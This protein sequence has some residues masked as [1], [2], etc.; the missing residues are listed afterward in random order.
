M[1]SS[2]WVA[3]DLLN[4]ENLSMWFVNYRN[5]P[6]Q[7]VVAVNLIW[8][9]LLFDLPFTYF[10]NIRV[11]GVL[12]LSLDYIYVSLTIFAIFV[13]LNILSG[14]NWARFTQLALTLISWVFNI[15]DIDE[16]YLQGLPEQIINVFQMLLDLPILYLLFT[17]PGN[18]WLVVVTLLTVLTWSIIYPVYLQYVKKISEGPIF[19]IAYRIRMGFAVIIGLAVLYQIANNKYTGSKVAPILVI[20]WLAQKWIARK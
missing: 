8:L 17:R 10:H 16:F 13:N 5:A 2:A 19:V 11:N 15:F 12:T 3:K 14:K 6:K 4:R 7:V 18:H 9:G 1:S 20:Y